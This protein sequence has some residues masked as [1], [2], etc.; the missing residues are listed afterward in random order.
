[1][2]SLFLACA[3]LG[4]LLGV[5][6]AGRPG[7]KEATSRLDWA[8]PDCEYFLVPSIV[9]LL[10]KPEVF[11]GECVFLHGY[12]SMDHLYLTKE[13]AEI[14]A[15]ELS[16]LVSDT[17]EGDLSHSECDG[18]YVEIEARFH[19]PTKEPPILFDVQKLGDPRDGKTCWQKRH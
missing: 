8:T 9:D 18:S 3:I 12:L 4:G 16:I 13:Y 17:D 11:D 19:V 6:C 15:F 10:Q 5:S 2:R 14:F 1:M 7:D